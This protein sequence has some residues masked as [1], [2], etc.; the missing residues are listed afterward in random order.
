[1]QN[2]A[3]SIVDTS[4]FPH[5]WNSKNMADS[6]Q[7]QQ[8]QPT[9]TRPKHVAVIGHYR[10]EKEIGEGNFAKVKLARHIL[11]NEQVYN[12]LTR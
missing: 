4:L 8:Q 9:A 7:K 12:C 11:T 2:N 6:K 1:M 10:L 3:K 5:I